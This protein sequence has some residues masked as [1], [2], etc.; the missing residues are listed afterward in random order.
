[1][2]PEEMPVPPPEPKKHF[3]KQQEM[4]DF[5]GMTSEMNTLS[6]RLRL[7]EEG[8]A[9]MRRFLQVTEENMIQKNRHFSAEIKTLT[10]DVT[11]IR[12]EIQDMKDKF[13][14]MIREF[15]TVARKEEVKILEKYINL[16]N[17]I[18]FVTQNEVEQ[19]IQEALERKK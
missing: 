4:P 15:Q 16:W 18:K 2:Q 10:S 13:Q 12:K 5:S 3:G 9:N 14:L 7:I 6:R 17:P 8:T 1:M 11:E 19:I